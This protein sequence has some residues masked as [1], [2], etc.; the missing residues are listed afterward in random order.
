MEADGTRELLRRAADGDPEAAGTLVDGHRDRLRLMVGM[1]M[2]RRLRPR[3]DASDVVQDVCLEALK[4]LPHYL[5]EPD[6]MPFFLWMR[7]LAGQRLAMLHRFHLGAKARDAAR[8]VPLDRAPWTGASSAV[9][10]E[11]LA[12]SVTSPSQAAVRR[13][14]RAHLRAALDAMDPLDREVLSLRHLEQLSNAETA[15]E[16]GLEVGAA[17]KRYIRA[18]RRLKGLMSG[19]KSSGGRDSP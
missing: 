6:P 1:R 8:D 14:M 19:L 10:A 15:R 4:R 3:L 9:L 5:R 16:L 13:E 18:F 17:S 2:D 11:G 7:F 12:A